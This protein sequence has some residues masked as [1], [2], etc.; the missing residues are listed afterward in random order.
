[1]SIRYRLTSE[2]G[3]KRVDSVAT[4]KGVDSGTQRHVLRT[5]LVYLRTFTQSSSLSLPVS[6]PSTPLPG[7]PL[8]FGTCP[9]VPVPVPVETPKAHY[10][11]PVSTPPGRKFKDSL[12]GATP[13]SRQSPP[14]VPPTS[15]R[16][17]PYRYFTFSSVPSWSQTFGSPSLKDLPVEV[18][19]S[20][21][22]RL[23]HS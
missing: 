21:I 4:R 5:H 22:L 11:R 10:G 14:V 18:R 19:Q 1:M 3:S 6:S 17:H 12:E 2:V 20:D 7:T 13:F 23:L 15:G 16:T 8:S 9:I